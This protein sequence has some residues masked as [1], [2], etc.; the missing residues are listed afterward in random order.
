M[1]GKWRNMEIP[2][3]NKNVSWYANDQIVLPQDYDDIQYI[4]TNVRKN[5]KIHWGI[6]HW[7]CKDTTRHRNGFLETLFWKR[8]N[9]EWENTSDQGIV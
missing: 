4:T 9:F 6:N 8:R 1:F 7:Q 2:I 5:K 3:N